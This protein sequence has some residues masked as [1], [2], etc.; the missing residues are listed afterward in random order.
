MS[1]K[2]VKRFKPKDTNQEFK[3]T[4]KFKHDNNVYKIIHL[5]DLKKSSELYKQ[6]VKLQLDAFP[7]VS[8]K[9][10]TDIVNSVRKKIGYEKERGFKDAIGYVLVK[11]GNTTSGHPTSTEDTAIGGFLLDYK[12]NKKKRRGKVYLLYNVAV[13]TNFLGYGYSSVLNDFTK[14]IVGSNPCLAEID[15]D[16]EAEAVERL[17][18]SYAKRGFI[19]H[20]QKNGKDIRRPWQNK[21]YNSTKVKNTAQDYYNIEETTSPRRSTR[22]TRNSTS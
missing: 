8:K 1:S 3:R 16:G 6:F 12:Q 7:K 21:N 20:E 19:I 10:I 5:H 14:E 11:I 4:A 13:A 22:S 2:E 9:G 15:V 17:K 18:S